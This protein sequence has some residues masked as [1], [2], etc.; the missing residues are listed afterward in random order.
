RTE[1]A[2]LIPELLEEW[3]GQPVHIEIIYAAIENRRPDL[4]DD[5]PDPHAPNRKQWKHDV[6]WELTTAVNKERIA[7]RDD[8]GRG[9]YAADI[10][11]HTG[12]AD[13]FRVAPIED[14]KTHSPS[15]RKPIDARR[16]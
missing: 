1:L 4:V 6:R 7:K 2:G 9:Y 15:L 10:R 11:T 3:G 5:E 13:S 16:I 8:I 12:P 14:I